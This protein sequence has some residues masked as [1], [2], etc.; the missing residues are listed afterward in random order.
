MT[1][2]S[3][4]AR[5]GGPARRRPVVPFLGVGSS[6]TPMD[7]G[8]LPRVL[9][10]DDCKESSWVGSVEGRFCLPRVLVVDDCKDT[11]N[12]LQMML[13]MWGYDVRVAYDGEA[14]IETALICQPDVI[15]L[16][17]G[18][19]MMQG[20]EVVER[21]RQEASVKGALMVAVSGYH[22]DIHKEQAMEAGFDLY[23]VKPVDPEVMKAILV[24]RK[25]EEGAALEARLSLR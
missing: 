22:D 20:C 23:H 12:S 9:V 17:L 14:A 13:E 18:M 8:S 7:G 15:F 6:R 25:R 24:Q 2:A 3:S 5:R 4:L 10:A 1:T 16:D 11:A 19:P 21:L